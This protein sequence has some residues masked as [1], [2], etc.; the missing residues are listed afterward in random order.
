MVAINIIPEQ[1]DLI[2]DWVE[3]HG[4]TFPILLGDDT[5]RLMEKYAFMGTP[6]NLLLDAWGG[7]ALRSEG[8]PPG[9][10]VKIEIQV[11]KELGLD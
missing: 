4:Y 10:E 8:Y 3:Q 1:E 5:D 2:E 9:A 6:L 7:I 11:R